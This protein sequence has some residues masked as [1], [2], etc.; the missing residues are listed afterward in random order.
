MWSNEHQRNIT[1]AIETRE[2]RER[3]HNRIKRELEEG[4]NQSEQL[5]NLY[6]Q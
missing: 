4:D 1:E 6:K 5:V 2:R 3:Y